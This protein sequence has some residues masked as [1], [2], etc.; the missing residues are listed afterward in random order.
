MTFADHLSAAKHSLIK[1]RRTYVKML[2]RD[3]EE[4][5]FRRWPQGLADEVEAAVRLQISGPKAVQR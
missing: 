5:W 3:G 4:E 2:G 1:A